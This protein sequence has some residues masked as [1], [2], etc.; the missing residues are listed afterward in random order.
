MINGGASISNMVIIS[1]VPRGVCFR[2][3]LH[4]RVA[5]YAVRPSGV[6]SEP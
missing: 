2:C 3:Y 6:S 5:K 4:H 1:K